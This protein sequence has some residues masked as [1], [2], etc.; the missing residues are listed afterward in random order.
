[1]PETTLILGYNPGVTGTYSLSGTGNLFNENAVVIGDSGDGSFIQSGGTNAIYFSI[2]EL[3]EQF[4]SNGFYSLSTGSLMVLGEGQEIIGGAGNGTFIQ[5]GGLHQMGDN[6][7]E[8]DLS[9]G[10]GGNGIYSLSG[11]GTLTVVEGQENVE[12]AGT[13]IQSGGTN[14]VSE[15]LDLTGAYTLSN[16]NL[17]AGETPS[18]PFKYGEYIDGTFSQSGGTNTIVSSQS[19]HLG[20]SGSSGTHLLSAGALSISGDQLVGDGGTGTFSLSATGSLAVTGTEDVGNSGNGTFTQTGGTNTVGTTLSSTNLYVGYNTGSNGLFSLSGTAILQDYGIE[21]IGTAGSGTFIQTGGTNTV[22]SPTTVAVLSVGSETGSTGLYSLGGTGSLQ[23][24]NGEEDIGINGSGTFTQSGGA[25]TIGSGWNLNISYYSGSTGIYNLSGTGAINF[26]NPVSSVFVGGSSSGAGGTGTLNVSGSTLAP[27][28][29]VVYGN[30]KVNQ[31]GG[32]ITTNLLELNSGSQVNLSGGTLSVGVITITGSPSEFLGN[33]TTTGW[34]GGTLAITGPRGLT[35][36]AGVALGSSLT[37]NAGQ[38]LDVTG[39][40]TNDADGYIH[41]INTTLTVGGGVTNSGTMEFTGATAVFLGTFDVEGT[42]IVDPSNL[43]FQNLTIGSAGSFQNGAGDTIAVSGNLINNGNL[44]GDG[45]LTVTGTVSGTGPLTVGASSGGAAT[46]TVAGLNQ[47]SVTV[48]TTG[49]LVINGGSSNSTNSL[50]I[51]GNGKLDLTNRHLFIDYGTGPD[52]ISQ[53][54]QYLQN[55]YNG[56]AWNGSGGIDSSA[57]NSLYGVGY[58]DGADG[59]VTGLSSGQIEVAYALLGD[60]NLDGVVNGV[61]FTILASN[62]G[63]SVTGWDK[64]DFDYDG[65]VTGIDFTALV[66]NLGKSA[67]GAD[68]VLPASD[69]VAIDAFAEANGLMA[70]VPEPASAGFLLAAGFGFMTRR[71]RSASSIAPRR[72]SSRQTNLPGAIV[73]IVA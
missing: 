22:A 28:T 46:L 14:T 35:V 54:R 34:A 44:S 47:P 37:I 13:F 5:S 65:A 8:I 18:G 66:R 6:E 48:D 62:L 36:G 24:T 60:A 19:L 57:A 72:F 41:V 67:S 58:A 25:N 27:N 29:L 64:G 68:V 69:Y 43:S 42:V 10:T 17:I 61:D 38:I 40:L 39:R 2:F 33:G 31:S 50:T 7:G 4:G 12:S 26:S 71:R 21:V 59:V 11:T 45:N 49:T 23:I 30:G 55:G 32:T 9:I 51:L 20:E 73:E 56:G 16:G 15:A 70:D 53:I 1:M 63:K 3:G 52:P